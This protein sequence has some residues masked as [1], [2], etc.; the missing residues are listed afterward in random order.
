MMPYWLGGGLTF[1]S[2]MLSNHSIGKF[3]IILVEMLVMLIR[4]EHGQIAKFWLAV[5]LSFW[6]F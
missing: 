4:C 6:Q 1:S 2:K 5:G 3:F